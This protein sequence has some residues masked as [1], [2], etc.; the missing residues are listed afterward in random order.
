MKITRRDVLAF[1]ATAPAILKFGPATAAT[2][3]KISHQFPDGS[4]LQ[5][6][7][8]DK[9]CRRFA[10]TIAPRSGGR[11]TA[12]VY[13]GSSLMETNSQVAALGKCALEVSLSP[14]SYVDGHLPAMTI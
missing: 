4:A 3:L 2:A 1:A 8:R 14:L 9:L 5:G 11:L 10:E 7:F 6:D 13:P 12:Q